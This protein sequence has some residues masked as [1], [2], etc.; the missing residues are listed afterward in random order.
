MTPTHLLK[1]KLNHSNYWLTQKQWEEDI[2]FIPL[3]KLPAMDDV[4]ELWNGL[5]YHRNG[6]LITT[7]L[8]SGNEQG[9]EYYGH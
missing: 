4:P 5:F 6:S 7:A 1:D 3:S 2:Y 8:I 9:W